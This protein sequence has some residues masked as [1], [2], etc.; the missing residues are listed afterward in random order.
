MPKTKT[1]R[2]KEESVMAGHVMEKIKTEK[3]KIKPRSF[4][5]IQKTLLGFSISTAILL[6]SFFVSL[7]IFHIFD[8]R[9]F[10]PRFVL[11][12]FPWFAGGIAFS[13]L[14][15]S[16]A[17]LEY[18]KVIYKLM[19]SQ[20]AVIVIVIFFALGMLV[21]KTQIHQKLQNGRLASLYSVEEKPLVVYAGRITEVR[22]ANSFI[23]QTLRGENLKI[24]TGPGTR[25]PDGGLHEGSALFIAGY[26]EGN[27][28]IAKGVLTLGKN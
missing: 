6:G 15:V 25:L 3:V 2:K 14:L 8:I 27:M 22:T 1:V 20:L 7:V 16:F 18:Y 24:F 21:N 13:L 17:L 19:L 4:F 5:V 23:L 28:I 26:K 11:S 12:H 10:G 9:I